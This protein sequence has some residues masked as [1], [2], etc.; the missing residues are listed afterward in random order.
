MKQSNTLSILS[1]TPLHALFLGIIATGLALPALAE[2]KMEAVTLTDIRGMRFCEILLVFD[3]RVDIYN[4]SASNDCPEDKWKAMDVA[5]IAAN[6]GAKAA[7]LNGPKFWAADGQTVDFAE[8]SSFGEIDAR[9]AASL[10]TSA[11][12][13][14]EGSSPYAH[15]TSS[16]NQTLVFKAGKPIYE[17]VDSNGNTYALNAYGPNVQGGDPANLADQ[18][19]PSEGWSFRVSTPPD[20]VVIAASTDGP[21]HMVGD[22]MHQYYTRFGSD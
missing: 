17:L 20:D 4:T 6:H 10:P 16:K 22:D 8:T 12:S 15:F 11:L 2:H 1:G 5:A 3:D 13:G 9:Y 21:V 7:Q 14:S 18:L 19:T